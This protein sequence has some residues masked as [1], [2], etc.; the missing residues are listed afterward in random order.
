[1]KKH[2]GS[3]HVAAE[4]GKSEG[5]ELAGESSGVAL[6]VGEHA[7]EHAAGESLGAIASELAGVLPFVSAGFAIKN[8]LAAGDKIV[9]LRMQLIALQDEA[10]HQGAA[11]GS[12]I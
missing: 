12:K 2:K 7:I 11:T 1:M 4:A 9:A 6:H 3:R 10:E 5:P 8:A